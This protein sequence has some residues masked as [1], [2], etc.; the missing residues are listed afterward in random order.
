M[1][2]L[3]FQLNCCPASSLLRLGL[4]ARQSLANCY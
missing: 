2:L 3:T 4:C 1:V